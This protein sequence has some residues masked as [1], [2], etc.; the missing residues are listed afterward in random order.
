MPLPPLRTPVEEMLA[1]I[2][3]E[4]LKLD[5][6]GIHDNFFEL[7]G[8]SLLATQVVSRINTA[9]QID[10]PLRRLFETPT[11]AGLADS[12]QASMGIKN[13]S[14]QLQPNRAGSTEQRHAHSLS[15]RSAYGSWTVSI[16]IT[17]P[18]TYRQRSAWPA[19]STSTLWNKA[20]MKSC[21]VTKLCV[22][23]L[24]PSMA[25]QCK[26]SCRRWSFR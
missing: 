18:I 14:R 15:L 24:P 11:I 23:S 10:F 1:N 7:G 2:W 9:F 25:I 5:K 17:Q 3:A 20:S 6:V 21:A 8:H 4:V 26:R 12:V 13:D 16:P 19:I 22:R